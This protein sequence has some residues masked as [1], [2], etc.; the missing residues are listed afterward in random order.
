MAARLGALVAYL[1]QYLRVKEVPDETNA[2][3]GLQV[4]NGGR[5]GHLIAAVDASQAVIDHAARLV[6]ELDAPPC[7]LVHHG[8]FWDGNQPVVDRRYRRLS[9]LLTHDVALYSSHIPLDVHPEVGNNVLLARELG[10]EELTPFD[11]YKGISMGWQGRLPGGVSRESLVDRLNGLLS[12]DARL[13]PG[14]PSVVDRV[15]IITGGA[16]SR[17]RAAR[18]AGVDTFI[19]GEGAHHTYFDAMELGVNTI[20][21]GHYATEQVGVKALAAHLAPLFDL[22]WSFF[23][24]PTGL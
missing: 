5:V 16:G 7:I 10:L 1:D 3:N 8:L 11:S 20:Y 2:V 24:H 13:I 21:A 17:I 12:T 14:G 18:E 6:G 22:G 9:T 4:A 19:T 15:A 23:D